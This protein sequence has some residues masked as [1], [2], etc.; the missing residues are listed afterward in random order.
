MKTKI[1]LIGKN[2]QVGADLLRVLPAL[3]DTVALD[4]QHLDLSKP[5]EIRRAIREYQPRLIVNAAAYTAVDKA[6]KEE[7]IARAINAEAPALLAEEAKQIGAAVVHYSSDYVF[8]GSKSAPYVEDDP[9]N[10]INAYGKTKLAG[11][12]G[13]RAS[14]AAHLIFRTSWVY[15]LRGRNFLLTILRLATERE[16]LRLVHDQI[17]APTWSREIARATAEVL[18]RLAGEGD[19][20]S[21][22]ARS[23][24]TYHMTAAGVTSW[25]EFALAILE[26]ASRLPQGTPWFAAATGGLPLITRRII[27]ITSPEYPTPARRPACSVL[28]N[29]RLENYFGVR[30]SD[31]RAQLNEAFHAGI[32]GK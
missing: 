28:S 29:S 4:R 27:P 24:G 5:E 23:G 12:E 26:E 6:E 14:G 18:G 15:A 32:S 30:L 19:V 11:E 7:A 2:G 25:H 8:D 13:I 17:G 16:E 10:P 3:G 22:L 21:A 20:A 1:L 9:P 31:W